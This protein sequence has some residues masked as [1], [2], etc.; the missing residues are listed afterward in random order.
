MS[1]AARPLRTQKRRSAMSPRTAASLSSRATSAAPSNPSKRRKTEA[2]QSS[3]HSAK[4]EEIDLRDADDDSGLSKV[5][6]QQRMATI[7]AQQE[8]ARSYSYALCTL[9]DAQTMDYHLQSWMYSQRLTNGGI[10]DSYGNPIKPRLNPVRQHYP[11]TTPPSHLPHTPDNTQRSASRNISGAYAEQM[12]P[13]HPAQLPYNPK[14]GNHDRTLAQTATQPADNMTESSHDTDQTPAPYEP[15]IRH[16]GLH[17]QY[18]D[19]TTRLPTPY[20]IPSEQAHRYPTATPH[21]TDSLVF[22][23][24]GAEM[25]KEERVKELMGPSEEEKE[26]REELKR[27]RERV[28]YDDDVPE[29]RRENDRREFCVEPPSGLSDRQLALFEEDE[30]DPEN[31]RARRGLRKLQRLG[32]M[33]EGRLS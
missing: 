12:P 25:T 17:L 26:E 1:P 16:L 4:I 31:W 20:Y 13:P 22:P 14:P 29:K 23:P 32:E 30:L 10:N 8:Q 18:V 3:H 6:E 27:A 28:R 15:K 33:A 19:P 2:S 5:L 21:R 7:K 24:K 11:T 9:T